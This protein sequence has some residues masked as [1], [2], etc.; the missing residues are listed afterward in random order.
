MWSY[1]IIAN[2][3]FV[4]RVSETVIKS[5]APSSPPPTHRKPFC[6]K[7]KKIM[8]RILPFLLHGILI[9]VFKTTDPACF[10]TKDYLY[11]LVEKRVQQI[12]IS[13]YLAAPATSIVRL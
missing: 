1:D 12:Y 11:H 5:E 13:L 6:S 2:K 4:Y 8:I 7:E 10:E 9:T 3:T